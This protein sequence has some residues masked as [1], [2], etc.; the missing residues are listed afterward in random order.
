MTRSYFTR[1]LSVAAL[2]LGATA[3]SPPAVAQDANQVFAQNTNSANSA[4]NQSRQRPV[5][6]GVRA[7]V[8]GAGGPLPGLGQNE[9]NFFNA[10][11]NVFNEVETVPQGLGPR[12]NLDSCGGC[13][14]Q[15][16]AGGSSPTTNPQVA[17]ATVDGAKNAV[18][19]FVTANGPI[20]EARFVRNPDGTPDGGVHDLFVITGRADAPGCNIKQ[21]DFAAAIAAR[22]IIF[23]IPT[24]VF[25][26]G[27]VEAV[28]DTGLQ[29]ALTSNAHQKSSLGISGV[30]NRSGNDGT[31]TRFGWKAQNKSL[32]IFAGEAYNVEMGVT[33]DAFPNERETDPSC[34]FNNLPESTTNLVNTTNSGS[35]AADFSQDIINF[36]AFMRM[37]APPTPASSTTPIVQSPTSSS[38]QVASAS[39]TSV[40]PSAAGSPTASTSGT[41]ATSA[42]SVTRGQQ[43]FA[44]VGCQGCHVVNQTTGKTAMTGQSNVTFQPLSDFALHS[45]GTGLADG[46][47]QG[48]ANGDQFRSAPLW[49]VGQ[50]VFFLHDGRTN[51]LV[52]AIEQHASRGSEANEVIENFN[53]LN[54]TD[55]QA[56]VNY[57][58]SL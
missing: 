5:D 57:L 19:A 46:V 42:A 49:G 53:M 8:P 17:N 10:A 39:A 52:A 32:L 31:I 4:A 58:R 13:H 23:R 29:T 56:L 20:R 50:R 44:N 21:P 43:V 34:Q 33:N 30:F 1:S 36:A 28:S 14:I 11:K 6:P 7:G 22:N 16:A 2:M 24:P 55:Q 40:L 9:L 35:P 12:F 48:N 38:V 18:P 3:L 41:S 51:D 15:P 45:M 27:L 54:V 25:G 26:T 37:L 47:S